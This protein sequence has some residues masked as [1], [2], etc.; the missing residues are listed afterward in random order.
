[1]TYESAPYQLVIGD[2]GVT[3]AWIV[4]PYGSAPLRGSVW[5][6]RE[7]T[8]VVQRTPTYAIVLAVVFALFCLLGLLFLLIKETTVQGVVEVHV[9][10][11]GLNHMTQLPV[12]QPMQV[13]QINGWVEQARALELSAPQ[14]W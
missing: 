8:F 1:M 4:T 13:Q 12:W 7:T 11:G 5:S 14:M 6:V 9:R 2:I 10:S 3:N